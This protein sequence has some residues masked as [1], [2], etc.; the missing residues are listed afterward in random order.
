MA[1]KKEQNGIISGVLFVVSILTA[2][3]AEG[4]L[5]HMFIVSMVFLFTSVVVFIAATIKLF[6]SL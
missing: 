2:L 4:A 1:T 3:L 6:K 5:E